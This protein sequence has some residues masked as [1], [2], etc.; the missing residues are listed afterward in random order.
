M[1]YRSDIDGLRTVAVSAVL[2]AH[3]DLLGATGGFVGVDVF[4]VISGYLITRLLQQDVDAGEFSLLKFYDRR[5]R[6]ILP[7]YLA[8]ALATGVAALCLLPPMELEN[9]GRR[10]ASTAAFVSNFYFRH[11]TDYFAPAAEYNPLLHMWS[12]SVEEQFYV[13]WPVA[14]FI[15]ALPWL[16]RWRGPLIWIGIIGSLGLAS[17]VTIDNPGR[18]FYN[19]PL[20]AWELL[21]GA[22]AALGMLPRLP[23]KGREAIAFAGAL[24]IGLAVFLYRPSD[25]PFPGLAALPPCLGALMILWANEEGPTRVGKILAWKPFVFTGLISY[26]LYLWHWP[27]LSFGKVLLLRDLEIHERVLALALAYGLA[28]LSWRYIERPFRRPTPTRWAGLPVSIP[29]ALSALAAI[30]A[31]GLALHFTQGLPG[32]TS[33]AVTFA[34]DSTQTPQPFPECNLAPQAIRAPKL[35][36]CLAGQK[37]EN[38]V[39]AVLIGDSHARSYAPAVDKLGRDMGFTARVWTKSSCT[40]LLFDPEAELGMFSKRLT[41]S[42]VEFNNRYFDAI[43]KDPKITTVIISAYWSAFSDDRGADRPGL[44]PPTERAR[45]KLSRGVEALVERLGRSGKSVILLGQPPVFAN[46]G[47]DCVVRQRFLRRPESACWAPVAFEHAVL[48]ASDDVLI[49]AAKG[50][51]NVHTYIASSAFCGADFCRPVD[52]NQVWFHDEHHITGPAAV[53]LTRAMRPVFEAAGL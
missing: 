53:E 13:I 44:R 21:L 4:F 29:V 24:A 6:R 40:P 39:V 10:L 48:S 23:S 31:G 16:K 9:F 7:A 26:S 38:A 17:I 41:K 47:G 28:V 43:A 50:R 20:R 46:G 22:T 18:A 1:K 3:A 51:P 5:V 45:A 25:P 30:F 34:E 11:E 49:A 12:L 42:C 33:P 35:T 19:S 14:I 37:D 32:R 15:L 8:M 27:I 2:L 52:G 36:G